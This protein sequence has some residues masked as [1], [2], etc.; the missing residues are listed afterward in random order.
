[1]ATTSVTMIA[2]HPGGPSG[3]LE[4]GGTYSVDSVLAA[5]LIRHGKAVPAGASWQESIGPRDYVTRGPGSDQ[6]ALDVV[7]PL[8]RS[9]GTAY[10]L[11]TAE[12]DVLSA[13]MQPADALPMSPAG[14]I[15][16]AA[17]ATQASQIAGTMLATPTATDTLT[18]I[19]RK[20]CAAGARAVRLS[21][22]G[23][24]TERACGGAW[25]TISAADDVEAAD[26]LSS[27]LP[28]RGAFRVLPGQTVSLGVVEG[29]PNIASVYVAFEYASGTGFAGVTLSV[30][31]YTQ[32][33]ADQMTLW[34]AS[35][36]QRKL[37]SKHV[38]FPFSEAAGTI[39]AHDAG[40]GVN[41]AS[42]VLSVSGTTTGLYA[43]RGFITPN[44]ANLN[45]IIM[46][47]AAYNAHFV[48][49]GL[50][51]IGG[52][53]FIYSIKCAA[54]VQEAGPID[55]YLFGYGH[56]SAA[57]SIQLF[58]DKTA[59]NVSYR[60]SSK[61][62]NT[63]TKAMT[64]KAGDSLITNVCHLFDFKNAQVLT[65]INGAAMPT[66][67]IPGTAAQPLAARNPVLLAKSDASSGLYL[68]S[69]IKVTQFA[70]F[71]CLTDISANF[72]SIVT[73]L[74]SG[75]IHQLPWRD[76]YLAGV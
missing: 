34:Q 1:M 74:G 14:I 73:A 33:L 54:F 32:A 72:Q 37:A 24:L 48:P 25:V 29:E 50:Q 11:Q 45:Q 55:Q 61:E 20:D 26:I 60:Y 64:I 62:N 47:D 23:W 49:N 4:A 21:L 35:S 39:T 19:V 75:E 65:G 22:S 66:M 8:R 15:T 51:G 17:S 63:L 31:A 30:S 58:F 9:D 69:S 76:L 18:R 6:Q 38:Y 56:F 7:Y 44:A 43:D 2:S 52:L 10:G 42:T 27:R 41:P 5:A 71:R 53:L 68:G 59:G 36:Y 46:S 3:L 40:I 13:A 28:S 57:N 67:S 70:C 12:G 16:A